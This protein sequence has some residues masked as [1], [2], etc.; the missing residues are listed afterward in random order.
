M[1]FID[2]DSICKKCSGQGKVV[3]EGK[4]RFSCTHMNCVE[5]QGTGL[6][7]NVKGEFVGGIG[8]VE[9]GIEFGEDM[10]KKPYER[11]TYSIPY[12]HEEKEEVKTIEPIKRRG[13]PPA[14]VKVVQ[15]A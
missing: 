14:S 13:R 10:P 9:K 2:P 3:S 12:Y 8:F 1:K 11:S 4:L 5:C 15:N 7:S 6:I